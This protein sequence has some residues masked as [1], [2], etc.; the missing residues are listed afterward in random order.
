M[1]P[2]Q[3]SALHTAIFASVDPAVVA[4]RVAMDDLE[5]A[6]LYN[7]PSTFYAWRTD[8]TRA[9]IYHS[10]SDDG[11]TW[12][13]TTYKGQSVT[14]QNAWVQIF[15]GDVANFSLDNLRAG[16]DSI[17]SGAGAP[18]TQRAHI[19]AIAKRLA[20]TAERVFATG[21]GSKAVPGKLGWQGE[22]TPQDASDA[23]RAA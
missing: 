12:N 4:A 22:L 9:E 14:E 20:T 21:T 1:T 19:A 2:S 8:V 23:L 15:M 6:R 17:F 3:L 7:L 10:T 18:A 13:W 5:I 16:V 11:T